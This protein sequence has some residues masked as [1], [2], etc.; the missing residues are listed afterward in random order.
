M[1]NILE[2]NIDYLERLL[3]ALKDIKFGEENMKAAECYKVPLSAIDTYVRIPWQNVQFN[4]V[5][6]PKQNEEMLNASM[7]VANTD[8]DVRIRNTLADNCIFTVRQLYNMNSSDLRRMFSVDANSLF[9]LTQ[10]MR[11][12]KGK[13]KF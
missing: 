13:F 12:N 9:R 8:L 5:A 1:A 3:L 7:P 6:T 10:W 4:V 11:T 2:D